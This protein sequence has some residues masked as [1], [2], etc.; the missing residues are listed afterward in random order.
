M[1][2]PSRFVPT[3]LDGNPILHRDFTPGVGKNVN[4]PS[5]VSAPPWIERPLGRYYLYFAHH[6][7]TFIRLATADE[8][9]G[10]WR[11]YQPGTLHL[12][13][14]HFP[15]T[16]RR[17]HIA[18]PDVHLDAQSATV[19]MYYH[20]LDTAT[21][22]QHTRVA[23]SHDG[24]HFHALPEILGRPYFRVFQHA[25]WWYALAMPGILYRSADGLS[26]FERG[27]KLFESS[28]RHSALL[29]RDGELFVFWSR[30][31]DCPERILCST[32]PLQGDWQSWRAAPAGEVLEPREP[33]E[34][35]DRPLQP[36][37]RGWMDEPVRQLR[38]PA[39]FE[40]DG[41]AYLLYSVAGESGIAI[42]EL[43]Q[44][45]AN[46]DPTKPDPAA[47]HA[48]PRA[49]L[50]RLA[51]RLDLGPTSIRQS[52]VAMTAVLGSFA[53]ALLIRRAADLSTSI[54]ILAIALA[55]TLGRVG[56]RPE[57]R[58]PRA[59]A[60]A[61]V[62]L[63]LI[64]I[65]ANEVGTTIFRHPD[66]GDTLFVLA[67]CATIW[68]RRFGDLARRLATLATLPLVAMLIVPAPI[69]G[70]HGGGDQRLWT[71]LVALLALAW[72]ALTQ[73]IAE[74]VGFVA[75][76][77]AR[78]RPARP[79]SK[80]DPGR[81]RIAPTTKMALQMGVALG[82][83]F[84]IG[85]NAFGT[86]WTWVVLSA[87]IVCSG[88]RGREDVLHKAVMRLLGAGA[89]TIAAT[90]VAGVFP[91]GD[92]W[93]IALLFVVLAV[94]MWLRPLNYAFWAA[95]MTAALA[96]LYGYYGEHGNDLL[97][98]R[99]EAITIG[100]GLGVAAS[101]LVLPIRATDIIRR[102]VGAALAALDNY[103]AGL[104]EDPSSMADRERRFRRVVIATEHHSQLLRGI[105]RRLR[106][107][108]DHLPAIDALERVAEMLPGV[109]AELSERAPAEHWETRVGQLRADI[110]EL[111][112]ANGR[113]TL[114]DPSA[115]NRVVDELRELPRTLALATPPAAAQDR[116]RTSS[117]KILAYVNRVNGTAFELVSALDQV[118]ASLTYAVS[119][120]AGREARL[121]WSRDPT[122][123]PAGENG[124]S[125]ALASGRTP[126][127]Y[128]Y[129]LRLADAV[130]DG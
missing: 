71:A 36:S 77:D 119:D 11:I 91:A 47:A 72:V 108:I 34:G 46:L 61:L 110:V 127:G 48:P 52:V 53:T 83:A 43:E 73:A 2:A 107:R 50:I 76:P 12:A 74:R 41:H 86:H 123:E 104:L 63:P 10:P 57:H 49:W 99:L 111:R 69:V 20:G 85:R 118:G 24:L 15:T 67:M 101:W 100:V 105:P 40:Q 94:A 121:S 65:A 7:G 58:G 27:P 84:A 75:P 6:R 23:V 62:L 87:F 37:V 35:A 103:L 114:P 30:V 42:A 113:A 17:P 56:Q 97:A 55:L 128:P 117:E 80:R 1:T 21:R 16:G 90:L 70:A 51:Q 93:S 126:S 106:T 54:E 130:S 88:S 96:L 82:A 89:G 28:M 109:T 122:V 44:T 95:G 38:D 60:L 98:T 5:L 22:K 102:D 18:S 4:G 33:W 32:I 31:G 64:A 125:T 129:A 59:R 79:Q 19:R 78:L 9:E 112:R 39:I 116:F 29:Q 25:G 92:D 66:L 68:M 124:D 81:R 45:Q 14:S 115:W 3:R 26:G 13:D 120:P 8:L